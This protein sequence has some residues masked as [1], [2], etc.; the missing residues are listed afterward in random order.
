MPKKREYGEDEVREIFALATVRDTE[1]R[2]A[3]PVEDGLTLAEIQQVGREVDID[4]EKLAEAA[5]ILDGSGRSW[6]R[7]YA[8]FSV[9]RGRSRLR[10]ASDSGHM[11]TC[12]RSWRHPPPARGYVSMLKNPAHDS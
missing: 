8:R 4:P 11:E 7:S 3:T 10:K 9:R 1:G 2:P 12:T 6:S 5:S